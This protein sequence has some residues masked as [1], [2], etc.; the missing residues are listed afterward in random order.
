MHAG[1]GLPEWH[2]TA[3]VS[4]NQGGQHHSSCHLL[5]QVNALGREVGVGFVCLGFDPVS[6]LAEVPVVPKG[7]YLIMRDAFNTHE[8]RDIMYR[9]C[10]VQVGSCQV[11]R[12][13]GG[14]CK[15]SQSMIWQ[16]TS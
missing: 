13:A 11:Q 10:T 4:F 12:Q 8:G 9:T 5:L 7:Q 2:G 16:L 1:C 15:P 14:G 3:A 6:H